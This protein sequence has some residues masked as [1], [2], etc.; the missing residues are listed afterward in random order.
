MVNASKIT[1]CILWTKLKLQNFNLMLIRQI[2]QENESQTSYIRK[3]KTTCL[4]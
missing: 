2:F 1:T 3:I 4:T